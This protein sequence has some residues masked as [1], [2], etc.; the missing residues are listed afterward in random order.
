LESG[1]RVFE[2]STWRPTGSTS[3]PWADKKSKPRMCLETAARKNDTKNVRRPNERRRR[4]PRWDRPAVGARELGAGWL[5]IGTMRKDTAHCASVYKNCCLLSSSCKKIM[6]PPRVFSSRRLMRFPGPTGSPVRRR[7][8]DSNRCRCHPC[9]ARGSSGGCAPGGMA[10]GGAGRAASSPGGG[11][12][13]RH[14]LASR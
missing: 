12:R 2:S 10:S 7:W 1:F 13:K 6:P 5:C 9:T 3:S 4:I 8:C 11:R 14:E